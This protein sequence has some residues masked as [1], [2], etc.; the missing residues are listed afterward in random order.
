MKASFRERIL[1]HILKCKIRHCSRSFS[2]G[3]AYVTTNK[4]GICLTGF[5][6]SWCVTKDRFIFNSV[7]RTSENRHRHR[8]KNNITYAPENK[9]VEITELFSPEP[10]L[11]RLPVTHSP[12]LDTPAVKQLPHD[13][14][15]GHLH[16]TVLDCT[17]RGENNSPCG[18]EQYAYAR[19]NSHKTCL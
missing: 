10:V 17:S 3:G 12:S 15:T 2:A 18:H 1:K 16:T 11:N 4:A 6:S 19:A 7:I 14:H 9:G 13:N 5:R 8:D